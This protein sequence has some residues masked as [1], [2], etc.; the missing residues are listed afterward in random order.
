MHVGE[1][2]WDLAKAFDCTNYKI[3]LDKLHFY[4]I[5]G[6]LEDCFRSYLTNRR[7]KDE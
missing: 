2:F 1:I 5:K 7:Q 3:L 4:G 6:V